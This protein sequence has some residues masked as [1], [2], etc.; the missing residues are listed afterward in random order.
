M[1]L[2]I[3]QNGPVP[4]F[5]PEEI[6]RQVF[7]DCTP[8]LRKGFM[9]LGLYE[10]VLS[11]PLFIHLMRPNEGNQLSRKQ[12]VFLLKP[13]FSEEGTNARKYENDVYA[14]FTKYVRKHAVVDRVQSPLA[15]FYSLQLGWIENHL[16]GLNYNLVFSL[17]LPL[18]IINDPLFQ[19][20]FVFFTPE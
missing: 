1:A 20:L 6:L 14:A 3:L 19:Q 11:L 17:M 16:L 5:V 9:K 7:S 10:I 8:E 18:K 4:R 13:S 2:G 12:L 15:A